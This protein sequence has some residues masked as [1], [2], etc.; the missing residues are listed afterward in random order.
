[1]LQYYFFSIYSINSLSVQRLRIQV[2]RFW[3][4]LLVVQQ[5]AMAQV[6]IGRYIALQRCHYHQLRCAFQSPL[7]VQWFVL[8][9]RETINCCIS[10]SDKVET[11]GAKLLDASDAV[12]NVNDVFFKAMV[13]SC[14]KRCICAVS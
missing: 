3:R 14:I 5:S 8:R 1:M 4:L 10:V 6:S 11:L 7:L 13:R 12:S 2:F 9:E